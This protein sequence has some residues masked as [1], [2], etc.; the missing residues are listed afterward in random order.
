[1][2][3]TKIQ[4]KDHLRETRLFSSRVI[5]AGAVVVL[6]LIILIA[7]MIYLQVL[8]HEHYTT[9]S[10]N[11]RVSIVSVPPPRGLIFDRNGKV[12]AENLP[13][14]TLELIPEKIKDIDA[15]LEGL[16]AIID[17]S[18]SNIKRFRKALKR[19]RAFKSLPLKFRLDEEEV[20][21]LS[22]RQHQFT[23]VD[24][25]AELM[26]HYPYESLGVHALGY[27][28]RINEKELKGLTT[29]YVGTTY[30]GK[31]GI[32]RYYEEELHGSVGFRK[33]ES[34]ARGRILRVL[35][36]QP[37]VPGKNIY[38]T[39]DADVQAAA[40]AGLKDRRGAVVAL[41][42][43][44]GEVL[45]L[46][47]MPRFDPNP[48]VNG[49][50]YKAYRE[51]ADSID[52]PLFNRAI[53]GG[54]PPGSTMKPFVGLAGLEYDVVH[55]ATKIACKGWFQ[56]PNSEHKYRDWKREGHG[57]MT[58]EG[59][60][61]ESCDVF[62]YEMSLE[63][64]ID[65]IYEFN[66]E[67]GFGR[68][69]GIDLPGETAGIL[70]SRAWKRRVKNESWYFGETLITAIGQGFNVT[71]PLQLAYATG[72]FA[73][74]GLK[75]RPHLAYAMQ[76]PNSDTLNY[77][78]PEVLGIVPVVKKG[79]WD[80]MALS[81]KRV[82]HSNRGTARRIGKNAKYQMAGKTGTAQVYGIKQDEK[83]DKENLEDRLRD[84]ALFVSYAPF[85]NPRIAVAVIVENGESGGGV[86]APIARKVMDAYL[87]PKM[88]KGK[89]VKGK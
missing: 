85:K 18:E 54:Y 11:N 47:S 89:K 82:V 42:P 62:F 68:R 79:N 38:L 50:E 4:L 41:D 56:L 43:Q 40:E 39:L 72:I 19:N 88:N 10:Q 76:E 23:G 6:L 13:S 51:L 22:V 73:N 3:Y 9:L 45:A 59:A 28:G 65:H 61:R 67:F 58:L 87:L 35:E 15:T 2:Q 14:F 52:R 8:S 83:Y 69:S 46:A 80:Y 60:I 20:A 63:L 55:G 49:I 84:H 24:I 1:M 16:Q 5:V 36:N 66:N 78:E 7:R 64:G 53:R 33:I 21:R 57:L 27:V 86:A 44:T 26:R 75:I 29:D 32:E 77:F 37:P 71:S 34:N 81:M 17:I 12:L 74:Y 70:P 48:F 31:T 25:K 30:I